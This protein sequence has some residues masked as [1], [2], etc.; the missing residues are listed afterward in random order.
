MAKDNRDRTLDIITHVIG[1]FSGFIGALIVY[2]LTRDRIT[3]S[4]S[5]N[6]LN[7]QISIAIYYMLF[8][9]LSMASTLLMDAYPNVYIIFP[10][11]II[12]GLLALLNLIFCIIAAFKASEGKY[13]KYPL[14]IDFISIVGKENINEA[15]REVRKAYREVKRDIRK[16][17]KR[18]K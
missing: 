9:V 6:A 15:K 10:F 8:M 14:S 1:I 5:V 4:H 16:E 18:K 12:L 17:S 3:K 11:S 7:W 2:L 13:W